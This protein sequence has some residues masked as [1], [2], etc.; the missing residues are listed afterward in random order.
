[1]PDIVEDPRGAAVEGA[2]ACRDH[3]AGPNRRANATAERFIQTCLREWLD[4]RSYR[5]SAERTHAMASLAATKDHHRAQAGILA[6]TPAARL[7]NAP[8]ND[9]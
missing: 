9:S 4:A 1:V 7:S 2:K 6:S 3:P 8:G 5:I